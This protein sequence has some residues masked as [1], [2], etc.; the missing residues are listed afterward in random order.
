MTEEEQT[1]D[2]QI[3]ALT[4][5]NHKILD[6][7]LTIRPVLKEVVHQMKIFSTTTDVTQLHHHYEKALSALSAVEHEL[8]P[9]DSMEVGLSLARA[10][11]F[12]EHRIEVCPQP[13][14][15]LH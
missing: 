14:L 2:E 5:A 1:L 13:E 4:V 11:S 3:S 12:E 6:E 15:S 7:L 9:A 8:N 10:L